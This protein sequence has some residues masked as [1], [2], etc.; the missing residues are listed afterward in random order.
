M[1]RIALVA[2]LLGLLSLG[3]SA[4]STL[5]VG[6]DQTT[7]AEWNEV[8]NRFQDETG[9]RVKL[10]PYPKAGV[11]Q[12]IVR[13]GTSRSG[14]LNLVMVHKEWGPNLLRYLANLSTYEKRFLEE[15][16][17]AAYVRG[18]LAGIW[19][20]F[21]PDWFLAVLSW[22]D[23]PN[24]AV[25]FL[26]A[27]G[28]SSRREIKIASPEAT[29]AS[30]RTTKIARS[31]HNPKIDG[32]LEVLLGA[33]Q[34]SA[35]ALA[36]DFMA[37]LPS[38]A[39]AALS[40]LA[41]L[42]GIPFSS[43]TSAV[44]VVLEPL[45]GRASAA[46][47]AA[48]SA[49]GVSRTAIKT[50]TSLIK[51]SVPLSLLE[52]IATQLGGITFIRP[53]Y[54]PYRLDITGQGVAAIGADAF[55]A[56][57]ITGNGVKVAIIDLGFAGLSQ[58]QAR[59]DVP[60]SVHQHDLTGTG[61][62]T[63]HTHGT[64]V[65]EILH[66][67]A[68]DAQLHLIKIADEV[69]L[70]LAVTYCLNNGIDVINHSLGWYNTNFYDGTG[71]IADI[72]KRAI[73]G[74]AMWVNAAGNEAESHWEGT[75]TDNNFDS[76]NDQSLA[77]HTSS[78]SQMILYMTWNDWP[79]ASSDYD[80]YLYDPASTLVASSTK[81]QTGTEEPTESIIA[82]A[83]SSGTYTV[84]IKGSGSKKIEIHN[85]YQNLSPTIASSS[86]L[87]PANVAQV[88]T[89][90]AIDYRHY[91]TGP[92]ESYS[93]Q[94]PTNDGRAKP[95][96]CA[97]DN[98]STGTSPYTSFAGTSGAA[99]H[100]AG[101][102]A[103]L[104]AQEP[105]LTESALRARLLSQTVA[106]GSVYVYGKGRLILSLPSPPNQAPTASF[107]YSPPSPLV[108]SPVR[109]DGSTSSD[110][111][112]TIVSYNWSFGDGASGTGTIVQH[113]YASIGTYTV[114]LT[115]TDNDGATNTA[116]Q[117]VTV[118]AAPNQAPVASFTYSPPSPLVGSPVRF[119]GSTSSDPDGTIVSYNWSFGDGASGTGTI[120][121]HTYAS[122]GTY[123]ARLTVTGNDGATNSTTRQ[124]TVGQTMTPLSIQLSLPKGSYQV[125]DRIVINYTTNREAYVYICDADASGKVSLIFP[126]FREPNNRLPAGTHSLPGAGYTL[127]V[128]EPT[129]SETLYAFAATSRLP[130]FPT[131]FGTTFK[132]LSYNPSSFKNGVR[133]TMQS[134]LPPGNWAEDTLGFTVVSTAPA[135]GTLLVSSSPQGASIAIDGVP[136]G[137]TPAQFLLSAGTH[138][139][140]ISHPGYRTTTIQ[141]TV[142]AGQT[143]NRHV[144]L[145]PL[146]ANQPPVANFTI[147][148]SNPSV[149]QTVF[150]NASPSYDP[151]G[152]IVS[153]V[154][155]L[156]D[157]N[158]AWGPYVSHTYMAG[159]TY[160]VQLTV[161]DD[162][163]ASQA[164]TRSLPVASVIPYYPP[165]WGGIPGGP[166]MGGIPGIFVWGT[167]T[168]HITVNAGATWTSAHSYKL[169]LRTDGS[170]ENVNQTISGGVAP[171]GIVPTPT[172][173]G[174]TLTFKES[175]SSG[176]IDYTFTVSSAKSIWM[177]LKL[178]IDGDGDLEES[179]TFIYLRYRMVHPLTAPFVVGLPRGSSGPLVPSM[180][181][182]IGHA[183]TYTST[184]RFIWWT[185]DISTLEGH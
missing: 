87:A 6:I 177:S 105:S 19:I 156:G 150:F 123:T 138:A 73:A 47:V 165:P 15:E 90:G 168:W 32:S 134:Q 81:H 50:S 83:T 117:Q 167:N 120:V 17:S 75:F 85:L 91:T 41:G 154:W 175:L 110:P 137:T 174:K 29:I 49:L 34:A 116:T 31:D 55:H 80:L 160:L 64:A 22:P 111:D 161:T 74:G 33:A 25:A 77:F 10:H 114:R 171:M 68:P 67:I 84:R 18:T 135:S 121:Q 40:G 58:A 79:R 109:F 39:R 8:I 37:K 169:E 181:F 127:W 182:R 184:V 2:F 131:S 146:A 128:S 82:T 139:V 102:A 71:T 153:Y 112:G 133:Q 20:P 42:Y 119:D 61:L 107:T 159:M 173:G 92:Q 76:F 88:V 21:A 5:T 125:G 97:P 101:A 35:G 96:L 13:Q 185:T 179:P 155:N 78:G 28:K 3:V 99:P 12:Q 108:G 178:D 48:L 66:E 69:D 16:V 158:S 24:T 63:G 26:E 51:V 115:V 163:G 4:Q 143:T 145:T 60:Y 172:E 46:S 36:T 147:S 157:G 89:V 176:S 59:G 44:T 11:A 103:L 152:S 72:A 9:V 54:I 144:P 30:F 95:D 38:T 65:A 113:P 129:G 45:G 93:S 104:L 98:V 7:R 100:A 43:S 118:T 106:M 132:I 14:K 124:I 1:K 126:N 140:S 141:V 57:G 62:T 151:D 70:D 94:G 162:K 170:F 183:F 166:P 56:A 52:V 122:V 27:V 180:N 149:G 86:I 23:D 130:N 164:A 136:S 53:P 142:I 148:P